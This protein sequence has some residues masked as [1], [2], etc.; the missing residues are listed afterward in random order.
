M[1]IVLD[2]V[3]DIETDFGDFVESLEQS[4]GIRCC[5]DIEMITGTEYTP[6]ILKN[7]K[8][9]PLDEFTCKRTICGCNGKDIILES[10]FGLTRND[11]ISFNFKEVGLTKDNKFTGYGLLISSDNLYFEIIK[12]LSQYFKFIPKDVGLKS[13][14]LD[15]SELSKIQLV[16]FKLEYHDGDFYVTNIE[17]EMPTS[18]FD[19]IMD[20]FACDYV[21]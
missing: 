19:S 18:E 11:F 1:A 5:L 14:I 21:I 17:K 9:I 4:N 20:S 15:E 2:I 16:P 12:E 3:N 10:S 8:L 7:I 13:F 6:T